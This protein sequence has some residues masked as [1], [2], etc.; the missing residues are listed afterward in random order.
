MIVEAIDRILKLGVP[1]IKEIDELSY[2]D[3]PLQLIKPPLP[4]AVICSTLQGLADLWENDMDDLEGVMVHIVSP[5]K[6]S[7]IQQTSDEYGRRRV[8]ATAEYPE[9]KT[10]PFGAWMDPESFIIAAQ[11]GF[12]RIKIQNDD[13]SF[14]KDLDYMLGVASNITAEQAAKH[15]DDGLA[16]R[17]TVSKGISLKEETILK[18]MINLAPYRTFAE[19]DQVL[20]QFVF[21][22]RIDTTVK[23]A[24]FEGDGGRW[25]IGAAAAMKAWLAPKFADTPIIS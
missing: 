10:F 21:R 4:D 25:K 23:L 1:N 7:I 17:V 16:Q 11:Q 9:C 6:V 12:Q 19:I 15:V 22:A 5:T 8:F 20:S 18:P 14:M 24:V 2:S 3:K 13:G